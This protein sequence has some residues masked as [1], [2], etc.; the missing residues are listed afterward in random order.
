MSYGKAYFGPGECACA[1]CQ[2]VQKDTEMSSVDMDKGAGSSKNS[3][4]EKCIRTHTAPVQCP[5]PTPPTAPAELEDS[6]RPRKRT[7]TR[8]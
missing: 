2:V 6:A 5:Y 4:I 8:Y 1:S 7:R 3:A